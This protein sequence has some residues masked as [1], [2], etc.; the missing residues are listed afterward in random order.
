MPKGKG[1]AVAT[2]WDSVVCGK[3]RAA[4]EENREGMEKIRH[5][6]PEIGR[7][8]EENGQEAAEH[9]RRGLEQVVPA[10]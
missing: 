5:R 4:P 6:P 9:V 1:N 2:V 10:T 3:F 8:R 7:R